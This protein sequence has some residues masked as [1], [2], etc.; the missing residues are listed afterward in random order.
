MFVYIVFISHLTIQL[1]SIQHKTDHI[2]F[3]LL[4]KIQSNGHA[5]TVN[6]DN[7]DTKQKTNDTASSKSSAS[8]VVLK[9]AKESRHD[10]E[11]SPA[12]DVSNKVV[13]KQQKQNRQETSPTKEQQSKPGI[14]ETVNKSVAISAQKE[15]K[16]ETSEPV[17]KQLKEKKQDILE[18][19]PSKDSNKNSASKQLKGKGK[20]NQVEEIKNKKNEKNLAKLKAEEKPLDY[21]D[22]NELIN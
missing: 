10:V 17:T 16:K 19:S 1:V 12:K 13:S 7:T 9:Q 14:K 15:N 2:L 22:G 3:F 18:K 21:D 8:K 4:Q 5:T 20:E 11:K 6:E